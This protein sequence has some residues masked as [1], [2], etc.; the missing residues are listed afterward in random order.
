MPGGWSKIKAY[1]AGF[2]RGLSGFRL[3][4]SLSLLGDSDIAVKRLEAQGF[5]I[6]VDVRDYALA[7]PIVIAGRYEPH[8]TAALSGELR[9]DT[10]FLDVGA[11]IG[12]FTLLVAARCPAG[13]VYS[14]E[15]DPDNARLL[16]ASVALNGFGSR[17]TVH[18]CA[19]SDEAGVLTL[20]DLG[21]ARNL[22]A[23]FTSKKHET[24]DRHVHGPAPKFVEVRAAR[25]DHLLDVPK[26]DLVKMDIEGFEPV[27]LRGME[28]LLGKHRPVIVMEFAPGTI[29]DIA[30]EDP[31]S[32]LRQLVAAGYELG[33][34]GDDGRAAS[35]TIDTEELLRVC[36]G[37]GVHHVDLLARPRR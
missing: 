20:S 12:F 9:E 17:V 2:L 14:I 6:L 19:A 7:K 8:V 28:G 11:N 23:R 31:E 34:L 4:R 10:V 32:A 1:G 29:R 13:R 21:N 27:A 25:L 24:L 33:I 35:M 16:S 26:L 37:R 36:E 22:G 3:R 18:S 30:G 5:S 15:P